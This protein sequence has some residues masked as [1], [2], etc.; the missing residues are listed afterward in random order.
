M[1]SITILSTLLVLFLSYS[2]NPSV[3]IGFFVGFI[4][5]IVTMAVEVPLVHKMTSEDIDTLPEDW[6]NSRDTWGRFH[7]LR[8]IPAFLGLMAMLV[9]VVF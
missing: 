4:I 1:L 7:F 9:S 5:L 3:F 2:S 6:E 8:M